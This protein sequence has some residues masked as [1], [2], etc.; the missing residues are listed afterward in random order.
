MSLILLPLP[1][2]QFPSWMKRSTAEYSADLVAAGIPADKAQADAYRTMERAFP[3][4]LPSPTNAV[5]ILMDWVIFCVIREI[6]S[7]LTRLTR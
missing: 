3:D 1:P 2:E 6:V 4:R 7:L 5:F